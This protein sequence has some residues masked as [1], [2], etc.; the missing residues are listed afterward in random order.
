MDMVYEKIIEK[1]ISEQLP[2]GTPLREERL[3]EEFGVS[4]TP[5]REAFR[6]LEYEGWVQSRPYQGSFT[7]KFSA[8]DIDELYQLRE[9]LE[10]MAAASAARNATEKELDNIRQAL[11]L[12][13]L[14]LTKAAENT[15][16]EDVAPTF[17]ED[18]DFHAAIAKASHNQLLQQR[19]GMLKAQISCTFILNRSFSD[20]TLEDQQ[21][22]F[23][24]HTM[25]CNAITRRWDDIAEL[26]IRRHISD[27][28]KKY[29]AMIGDGMLAAGGGRK[30]RKVQ[31]PPEAKVP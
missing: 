13:K 15:C 28:R 5:V 3:A 8:Q 2:P 27:A 17:R 24:E 6:R 23:E 25:I 10:G 4:S 30:C 18:L 29:A 19:L 1:I 26:L 20:G 21:R 11:D 14:Y 7:R 31:K 12:E 16:P 22:V 9:V